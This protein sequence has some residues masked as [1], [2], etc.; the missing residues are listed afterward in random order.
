MFVILQLKLLYVIIEFS[1]VVRFHHLLPI[2]C[3]IQTGDHVLSQPADIQG[4]CILYIYLLCSGVI[5]NL[6]PVGGGSRGLYIIYTPLTVILIHQL[7]KTLTITYQNILNKK[8]KE[9]VSTIFVFSLTCNIE[10]TFSRKI[11]F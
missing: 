2:P 3:K 11:Y 5:R 9:V 8:I 4:D 1:T 6:F 7:K 10:K